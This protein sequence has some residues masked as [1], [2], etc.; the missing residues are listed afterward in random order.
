M[1]NLAVGFTM[2]RRKQIV[3]LEG[4]NTS[5]SGEKRPRQSPS[6]EEAQKDEAIV[7]VET[8]NLASND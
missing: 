2:R 8:L 4:A 1:F 5:S 6:Y 7:L 3:T